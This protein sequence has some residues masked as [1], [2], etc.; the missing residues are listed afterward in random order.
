MLDPL[1]RGL[2][3][4]VEIARSA[5]T[6]NLVLLSSLA[7]ILAQLGF[8]A[9][10]LYGSWFYLDDYRLLRDAQ[11][12]PGFGDLFTPYNSHLM[13]AG[14]LVALLVE[15]S[16]QL[17]WTLAATITLLF[18]AVASG[19][20]VW[21]LVTLFG[22]R[23]AVL[24]PLGIYLF[25]PI[26]LPAMMWWT[27]CLSQI[28]MQGALFLAVGAWVRHLRGEG[29]RWI[30][31]T[32]VGVGY[33]LV[34][35]VKGLL[36]F[37]VLAYIALAYFASG[38]VW[39]RIRSVVTGYWPALLV[40]AGVIV[41]YVGYYIGHVSEPFAKISPSLIAS[42][43]STMLGTA[44]ASAAVGG[45]WNWSALA[46]PNAFADP[47][48][49]AVHAAWVALVLVVLYSV[50]RR[51]RVCRA[52]GLLLGYL[53]AL[54]AL[55]VASRGP[56][57]GSIIGLEYRYLTEASCL[58]ALCVALAF[59]PVL[60]ARE[61]SAR[62][63]APLLTLGVTAPVAAGLLTLV[64]ASSVIST[65]R[66]VHIWHTQN[67]SDTYVHNLAADLR[68]YGAVDLVDQP[69][70]EAV[71]PGIFAPD[72]ALVRLVPL[73]S[74]RATFPSYSSRLLVVG[75]D[76]GLRTAAIQLGVASEPGPT[77]GCGW[78]VTSDGTRI[79]MQGRAFR[80]VWWLRI[81]YLA[82]H[83]S[84][85]TVRAGGSVVHTSVESGVHSLYVR[86][87][88]SFSTVRLD[89]LEDGVTLCVDTVEA[90]QPVPGGVPS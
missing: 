13:P 42:I 57:F 20:A 79:P 33:A 41:V 58:L 28:S 38:S 67:A 52:W 25:N 70:P 84:P 72:N 27:A 34:F 12:H 43:A 62:R 71:V 17:N 81:G 45:P 86:V 30:A 69:V 55:L 23:W 89:G 88:G 46:P 19:A 59:L 39:L 37:P 61:S 31:V 18:Q 7:M 36:I 32:L 75:P 82:S 68:S 15:A 63:P 90:G 6:R 21:M 10:A 76:G 1:Y 11:V 35:D 9:W 66:Y 50:L 40:G 53:L 48:A 73:L 51:L 24:A 87:E 83:D 54:L 64:T 74:K 2:R 29:L 3:P 49:T 5:Q 14:R 22:A 65:V 47:P 60:G 44:F 85:M 26:S 4:V 78:R 56:A 80:W 77:E 16:G 8:R